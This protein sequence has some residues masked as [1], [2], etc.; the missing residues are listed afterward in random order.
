MD[1]QYRQGDVL[2]VKVTS[3]PHD[4]EAEKIDDKHIILAY[5]ETTG[6]A[7]RLSTAYA[8]AYKWQGNR[9]IE[10]HQPSELIHEEHNSI[11]LPPGVYKVVLQ[12][13]Y[14]PSK[15]SQILD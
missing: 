13:E 8:T 6:H 3:L 7:H 12:R 10:V 4:A 15:I 5:G 9:L 14:S 2:L 1:K 11:N